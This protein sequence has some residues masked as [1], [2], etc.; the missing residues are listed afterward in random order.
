MVTECFEFASTLSVYF[1]GVVLLHI[2]VMEGY[3]LF[4][5]P[6]ASSARFQSTFSRTCHLT[7][8]GMDL[9]PFSCNIVD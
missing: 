4:S 9:S 7:H 6:I 5:L 8:L 1:R 3:R 2:M